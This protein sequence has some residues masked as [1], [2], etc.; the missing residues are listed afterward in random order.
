MGYA[1]TELVFYRSVAVSKTV[2]TGKGDGTSRDCIYSINRVKGLGV[3]IPTEPL[4]WMQFIPK[5]S[6][7]L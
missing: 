4:R 1:G 2:L 7:L 3:K 5:A 6:T